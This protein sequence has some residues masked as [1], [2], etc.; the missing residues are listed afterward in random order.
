MIQAPGLILTSAP[1]DLAVLCIYT[2]DLSVPK[3]KQQEDQ[4]PNWSTVQVWKIE[5]LPMTKF[6]IAIIGNDIFCKLC[7]YLI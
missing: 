6:E 2:S 4:S 1:I 5:F 7:K 3:R